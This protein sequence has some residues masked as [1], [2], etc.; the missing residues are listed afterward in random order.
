[1]KFKLTN[2]P[3]RTLRKKL[4]LYSVWAGRD[5]YLVAAE[6]EID[7]EFDDIRSISELENR[8]SLVLTFSS[9]KL[10]VGQILERAKPGIV[11][12]YVYKGRAVPI[13]DWYEI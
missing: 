7:I 1:M 11:A 6:S 10:T 2:K 4:K 12:K 9:E 13:W 3:D 8:F 5:D